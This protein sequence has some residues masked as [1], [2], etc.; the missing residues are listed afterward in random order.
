MRVGRVHGV[1]I[2]PNLG[3]TAQADQTAAKAETLID[4]VLAD[5]TRKPHA[6]LR[7]AQSRARP[8][9]P[10]R[11]PSAGPGSPRFAARSVALLERYFATGELTANRIAAKPSRSS[12]RSPT[13]RTAT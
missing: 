13:S 7:A 9:D 5:Q 11:R 8:N 10:R 6:L 3:Q 12:F 1:N 4:S 2:S